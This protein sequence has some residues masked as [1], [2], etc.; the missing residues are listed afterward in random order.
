MAKRGRRF[1]KEG[2]EERLKSVVKG[3]A[4]GAALG[5]VGALAVRR[6]KSAGVG[7]KELKRRLRILRKKIEKMESKSNMPV[8]NRAKPKTR[9][10]RRK[11]K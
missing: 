2:F 4:K 5:G 11:S 10:R 3:A 6:G 9:I 8:I 7:V 1:K